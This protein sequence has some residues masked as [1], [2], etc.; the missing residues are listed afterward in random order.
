[1]NSQ[2]FYPIQK[3]RGAAAGQYFPPMQGVIERATV[4]LRKQIK[5]TTP[6]K[7][8]QSRVGKR[9]AKTSPK[10]KTKKQTQAKRKV[11]KPKGKKKAKNT[12]GKK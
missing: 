3:G 12:K 2:S 6:K 10:R 4:K 11:T 8:N 7:K 9:G 1:M 5:K